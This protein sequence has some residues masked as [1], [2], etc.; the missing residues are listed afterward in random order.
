[1]PNGLT[2][3]FISFIFFQNKKVKILRVPRVEIHLPRQVDRIEQKAHLT[4]SRGPGPNMLT[5]W[6]WI[7]QY[8]RIGCC[9]RKIK[10]KSNHLNWWPPNSF[11]EKFINVT[12]WSGEKKVLFRKV[13]QALTQ[14][15]VF[16][17]KASNLLNSSDFTVFCATCCNFVIKIYWNLFVVV[18]HS[19]H[20]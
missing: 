17:I 4:F 9:K 6:R 3:R 19:A 13:S 10:V 20:Q 11:Y 15:M 8:P 5:R 1:M 12:F 7:R 18:A 2:Y 14:N 16:S